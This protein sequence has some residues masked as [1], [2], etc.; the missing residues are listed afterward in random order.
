MHW[1]GQQEQRKKAA[2]LHRKGFACL[3]NKLLIRPIISAEYHVRTRTGTPPT[4]LNK[5]Y[6]RCGYPFAKGSVASVPVEVCVALLNPCRSC[7]GVLRAS[8]R[9]AMSAIC[10]ANVVSRRIT[11][12]HVVSRR[13]TSSYYQPNIT[14][15][16]SFVAV[17]DM[18][19]CVG[20]YHRN[21]SGFFRNLERS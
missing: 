3:G 15:L 8:M 2:Y 7:V 13:I 12:Y 16:S 11:S 18:L 20:W 5:T 6:E 1:R 17:R 10:S 19:D 4:F 21:I 14:I 9:V